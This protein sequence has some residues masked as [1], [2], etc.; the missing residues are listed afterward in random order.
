[1]PLKQNTILRSVAR[2]MIPLIVLFGL[3]VQIHG[4]VSA[5]GGFQA[6]VIVASAF[7]LYALVFGLSELLKVFPLEWQKIGAC[8]GVML[9]SGVGLLCMLLGGRFLDYDLLGSTGPEGQFI[10]IFLIELGVG[11]TV[12]SVILMLFCLFAERRK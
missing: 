11:A 5:G 3:Y 9:Y 6:G 10:G 7:M 8:L 1:M 4:K 2:G 12:F